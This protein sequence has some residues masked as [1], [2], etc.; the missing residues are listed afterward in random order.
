MYFKVHLVFTRCSVD[1]SFLLKDA[2]FGR[3]S[4]CRKVK[5]NMGKFL[6]ALKKSSPVTRG[7]VHS[8]YKYVL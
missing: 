5:V 7:E 4:D 2:I 8:Y 3:I 6:F 1:R